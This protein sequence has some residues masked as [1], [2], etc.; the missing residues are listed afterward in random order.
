MECPPQTQNK[1]SLTFTSC[2]AA[3]IR[4]ANTIQLSLE[5]LPAAITHFNDGHFLPPVTIASQSICLS[6]EGSATK[7]HRLPGSYPAP[8]PDR[9]PESEGSALQSTSFR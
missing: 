7:A 4:I 6:D 2:D 8:G 5:F 1:Y 3:R 9:T